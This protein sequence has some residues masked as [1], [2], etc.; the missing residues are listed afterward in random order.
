MFIVQPY[1][2]KEYGFGDIPRQDLEKVCFYIKNRTEMSLERKKL[3]HHIDHISSLVSR[4]KQGEQIKRGVLKNKNFT[5]AN[6]YLLSKICEYRDICMK[7]SSYTR[8]TTKALR[9][10]LNKHKMWLLFDPDNLITGLMLRLRDNPRSSYRKC[11]S[12]KEI[13]SIA[14]DYE[15]HKALIGD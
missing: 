5:Q 6:S 8:K 11:L 10:L 12:Y 4:I 15:F 9:Q 1:L 13:D 14:K 2:D 7:R 3:R